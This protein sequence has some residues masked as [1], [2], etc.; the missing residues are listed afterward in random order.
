MS[1]DRLLA[2]IVIFGGLI[3]ILIMFLVMFYVFTITIWA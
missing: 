2:G 1:R 3:I